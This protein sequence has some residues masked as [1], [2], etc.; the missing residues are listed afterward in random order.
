MHQKKST[1]GY[2]HKKHCLRH[3]CD[4]NLARR[5]AVEKA[6]NKKAFYGP[7]T[8]LSLLWEHPGS[9]RGWFWVASSY[10]LPLA[11]RP[12]ETRFCRDR[13]LTALR[14]SLFYQ[15]TAAD[16]QMPELE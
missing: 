4:I 15:M 6:K 10:A 12:A 11:E 16:R 8:S 5:S 2:W 13:R 1:L 3:L 9:R 14:S 7:P